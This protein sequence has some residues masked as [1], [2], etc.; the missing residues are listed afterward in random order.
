MRHPRNFEHDTLDSA[1]LRAKDCIIYGAMS[2]GRAC[3]VFI[4]KTVVR[5]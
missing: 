4:G 5:Q 3:G 1:R 2:V